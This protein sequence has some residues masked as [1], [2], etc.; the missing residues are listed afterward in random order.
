MMAMM[1]AAATTAFAQDALVKD[2]KKLFSK[3]EFDQALQTLAPALTSSET[4][5]KAAAWNLQSEIYYGKFSA[6]QT[7]EMESKV[8]QDNQPYDT[9]GM[10]TSAISAWESVLKCDEFDQQPDAKGKVK[11]KYR[12]AAQTKYKNFG[13]SLV[14][15]GQFM[16]NK[17]DNK[18]ALKGWSSYL[19][20]KNTPIFAEVKDFPID[21]FYHEIAY[22]TAFLSYQ[23]KNYADA[24]K[25]A[26]LAAQNPEK[27]EDANEILLFAKKDNCK[28]AEDSLAY[29]QWLKDLHK[30]KPE[31]E[32]YFNLLMDY[33]T[34]KNDMKALSAWAEEEI[35]LNA[36]NKMAWALKGEVQMN[37][38]EYDAAV[39]SYKKAIEIDPEFVQ[40]V[41]NAGVCLN[42]KAISLNEQL[43]DKKTGGLTQDNANKVKAVLA[44]AQTFL[45]RAREL[46]GDQLKV[47]WA[48]PLYRIYYSLKLTDKMAELE[49]ID[50]SL[51]Q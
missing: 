35:A 45:E 31:E 36:Q 6:I 23:E 18:Q 44:E 21:P 15:A 26:M 5:D 4:Q 43:A 39:E 50:P 13:V 34:H 22:Y 37:S 25:Y 7:I 3:N 32:R 16:Y 27:V 40:C 49:A 48:Y 1:A 41:F 10:W 12:S 42:S 8:K 29:V 14:Q 19:N 51:K 47:K 28:T 2:A 17:K 20:M 33:Y 9:L 11:L 46:D 38:N 24:E 30:A